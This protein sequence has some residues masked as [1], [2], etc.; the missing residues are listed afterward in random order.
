MHQ[1]FAFENLFRVSHNS[2]ASLFFEFEFKYDLC[3]IPVINI[4]VLKN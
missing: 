1:T 2:D 3:L 4:I